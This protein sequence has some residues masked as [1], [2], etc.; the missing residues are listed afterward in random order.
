MYTSIAKSLIAQ[1]LRTVAHQLILMLKTHYPF[2]PSLH[3]SFWPF[4]FAS[5]LINAKAWDS[6]F[7]FCWHFHFNLTSSHQA[8]N[9]FFMWSD[10]LQ[11]LKMFVMVKQPAV[12]SFQREFYLSA[13]FVQNITCRLMKCVGHPSLWL[14]CL[15]VVL[16]PFIVTPLWRFISGSTHR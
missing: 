3:L 13:S 6:A 8:L 9:G 16:L 14:P 5:P 12:D 7:L 10:L 4:C 11:W 15:I 1:L 2:N